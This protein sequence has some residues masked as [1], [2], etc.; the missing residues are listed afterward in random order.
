MKIRTLTIGFNLELPLK[1]E[2]FE[3]I[4]EVLHSCK[5]LFEKEGY[6][7]QTTR[8]TTQPW[9]EYLKSEDQIVKLTQILESFTHKYDIDYFSV[10]TTTDPNNIS[11]L[12]DIVK[13]TSNGFCSTLVSNNRQI[14]YEMAKQTSRL[15]KELSKINKN[16]FAN[17]RFAALFNVKPGNPF[18]PASYHK[19]PTSLT[20]GTENSDLVNKAF[21]KVKNIDEAKSNLLKVLNKEYQQVEKIAERF[22]E[23]KGIIYDGIDVSIATS[24][25]RNESVVYAFEKLGFGTFGEIGTLSVAYLVTEIL[26]RLDVKSCGYSGLMLPVLED[27]G[28]AHRNIEGSYNLHNLLLYSSICGTGLDLIPLPGNVSE[29]KIYALLLDVA[30]ISNKLNK[31]LSARL[32]PIPN[33][34]QGDMTEFDFEYFVNSKIMKI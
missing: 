28:L 24:V 4:A 27:Y 26:K 7:V 19:G 20:I 33:K 3:K 34:N 21:S 32:M 23:E 6:I 1:R 29:E 22:T 13:K 14:N 8:V 30:S 2:E 11:L 12:F 9:E 31:Q 16:G 17:L 10:G 15:I 18:F 5:K 25:G